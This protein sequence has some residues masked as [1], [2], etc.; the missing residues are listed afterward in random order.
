MRIQT[1]FMK[2]KTIE[3]QELHEIEA[4]GSMIPNAMNPSSQMKERFLKVQDLASIEDLE[5]RSTRKS[6]RKKIL[7]DGTATLIEIRDKID[8][9]SPC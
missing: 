2:P 3:A 9:D 5:P 8:E 1:K 4:Q 6:K 7:E